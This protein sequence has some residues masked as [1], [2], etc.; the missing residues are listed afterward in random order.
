MVASPEKQQRDAGV[1]LKIWSQL[2][3]DIL[4]NTLAE[5]QSPDAIADPDKRV[6]EAVMTED[7]TAQEV[8]TLESEKSATENAGSGSGDDE[9][10][11]GQKRREE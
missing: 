7:A 3:A 8:T 1:S 4:A 10:D 11:D 5:Q 6:K 9:D 2:Q